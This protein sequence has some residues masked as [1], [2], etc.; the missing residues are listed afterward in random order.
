M[1]YFFLAK[2]IY[3]YYFFRKNNIEKSL[4]PGLGGALATSR[5]SLD[6]LHFTHVLLTAGQWFYAFPGS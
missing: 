6:S 3:I 5:F 4:I 2:I 1:Y